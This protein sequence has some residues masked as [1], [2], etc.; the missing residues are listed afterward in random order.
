MHDRD[1]M[2]KMKIIISHSK[3]YNGLTEKEQANFRHWFGNSV[4]SN[5]GK[6]VMLFHGTASDLHLSDSIFWAAVDH[7]FAAEYADLHEMQGGNA[8]AN[9]IPVYMSIKLPF[10]ADA[11]P[12]TIQLGTFFNEILTQ[13]GLAPS[14][15]NGKQLKALLDQLN[16][17]RRREESGPHYSRHDF[18][19]NAR[20][21]FGVDG[22]A[23]LEALKL[24][25]FD[26]IKNTEHGVLTYG[27]F[28]PNQVKSAVGN[29]GAFDPRSKDITK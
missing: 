7:K 14:S 12:K 20:S 16:V 29:N 13:S 11:L 25:G 5:T 15:G 27:A 1:W 6:P 24:C 3:N 19:Y 21:L 4:V 18:W 9:I 26:G 2:I 28:T 22:T 17:A 10:D 8:R 23:I